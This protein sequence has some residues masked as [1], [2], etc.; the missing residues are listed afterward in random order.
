MA[1]T[2]GAAKVSAMA[3]LH[4][5]LARKLTDAIKNGEK[6]TRAGEEVTVPVS[7][8]T[9]AVA[10]AFLRDNSIE[11]DPDNTSVVVDL[12]KAV[13]DAEAVTGED[14]E[15]PKFADRH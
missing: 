8:A 3:D 5:K 14:G 9:L 7:S 2:E 6:V 1:G 15:I 12:G 11:C 4:D 13:R 10:R